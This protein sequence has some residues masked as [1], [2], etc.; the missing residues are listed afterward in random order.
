MADIRHLTENDFDA[1]V[2]SGVTLVDFWATWCGPCKM[3]GAVIDAEIAPNVGDGVT[4][5]KVN[6]DDAPALAARFD[7]ASIPTLI[8]FRDGAPV[9]RLTGVTGA[10][11]VL[12]A[13]RA[14]R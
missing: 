14:A 9:A 5:A 1:A 12:D 2:A 6:V 7:V 11:T 10:A 13:V 8:V 4:I 3:M